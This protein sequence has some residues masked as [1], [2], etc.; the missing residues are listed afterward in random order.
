[1]KGK[2]MNGRDKTQERTAVPGLERPWACPQCLGEQAGF[3]C[4]DGNALSHIRL[5]RLELWV[6]TQLIGQRL[7]E[8]VQD[9]D[10]RSEMKATLPLFIRAVVGGASIVPRLKCQSEDQTAVS[11]PGNSVPD[12]S[13]GRG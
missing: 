4:E 9:D 2:K 10:Y 5:T 12:A 7:R 6:V 11:G 13:G 3:L 8:L 1:M